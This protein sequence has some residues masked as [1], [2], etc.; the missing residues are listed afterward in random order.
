MRLVKPFTEICVQSGMSKCYFF[1]SSLIIRFYSNF[2]KK[3]GCPSRPGST[4]PPAR[5]P[6]SAPPYWSVWDMKCSSSLNTSENLNWILF[7]T[8]CCSVWC[9]LHNFVLE[10]LTSGEAI[11]NA[12]PMDT[13]VNDKSPKCTF[14][15]LLWLR[16]GSR[17]KCSFPCRSILIWLG[18]KGDLFF[19]F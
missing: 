17:K 5:C 7:D 14:Y 15:K 19:I 11:T 4:H 2:F 16:K 9:S 10:K 12:N 8:I 1:Y 13:N 6:L 18:R 3:K